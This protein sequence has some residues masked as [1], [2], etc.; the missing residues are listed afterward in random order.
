MEEYTAITAALSR[1][2]ETAMR[3]GRAVLF[4]A[5]ST[6]GSYYTAL[7]NHDLYGSE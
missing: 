5:P 3:K 4:S 1:R 7:V 6:I 2:F